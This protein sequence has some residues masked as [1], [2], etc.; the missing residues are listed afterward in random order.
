MKHNVE[1][2]G[3]F[4]LYCYPL[5]GG[6]SS[7]TVVSHWHADGTIKLGPVAPMSGPMPAMAAFL[8]AW[9]RACREGDQRRRRRRWTE[10]RTLLGDSQGTPVEGVSAT[11]RLIDEDEVDYIIGDVS[12]FGHA[13]NAAP[14]AEDAEVF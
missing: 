5:A 13:R 7:G 12:S 2:Q 3:T 11:R 10:H 1:P 9:C 4:Y 8:D 14:S 6:D